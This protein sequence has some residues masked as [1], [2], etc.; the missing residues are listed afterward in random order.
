MVLNFADVLPADLAYSADL[1]WP[2][3][4]VSKDE[5]A[6]FATIQEAISQS[7][8]CTKILIRP[9][10]YQG[11]V[12]VDRP[13]LLAGEGQPDQTS[14]IADDAPC[15]TVSSPFVSIENLSLVGRSKRPTKEE[16]AHP[17]LLASSGPLVIQRCLVTSTEGRCVTLKGEGC[18]VWIRLSEISKGGSVGLSVEAKAVCQLE[19]S[20]VE[21]H[22]GHCVQVYD[23]GVLTIRRSKLKAAGICGL[24]AASGGNAS[25]DDSE[26]TASRKAGVLV[27]GKGSSVRLLG[28]S[29]S[30]GQDAGAGASEGG[31]LDIRNS[32][33]R[34]NQFNG[35]LIHPGGRLS[36]E[37]SVMQENGKAGLY[38]EDPAETLHIRRCRFLGN[39][40][41]LVVTGKA[42]VHIRK[43]DIY[44]N[45]GSGALVKSGARA[46]LDHCRMT[47]NR[48]SGLSLSEGAFC[49]LNTCTVSENGAS[50]V[51]AG[52][53]AQAYLIHCRV[54]NN[55]MGGVVAMDGGHLI[56]EYCRITT[57]RFAGV[58][59]SE[60]CTVRFSIS[61]I[62]SGGT[63]IDLHPGAQAEFFDCIVRAK[64]YGLF[65]RESSV[66]T[67]EDCDF[68]GCNEGAFFL[69]KDAKLIKKRVKE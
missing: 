31:L 6:D 54:K 46:L 13:V 44:G 17:S 52:T 45:K 27:S 5:D 23:A 35:V 32:E 18:S 37:D 68:S 24:L 66:C 26:I 61:N 53:R 69:W 8:A 30:N 57:G 19:D 49:A 41:G 3:V 40:H 64:R 11:A 1:D 2:T 4:M 39:T 33:I 55:S 29:V 62:E 20:T 28:S 21:D 15:V 47:S 25:I 67:L 9:G 50:G 59:V 22:T 56:G 63:A 16:P 36:A 10:A 48:G 14:I 34:G 38:I 43:S 58:S 51:S 42:S 65:A 60:N 12:V 7:R